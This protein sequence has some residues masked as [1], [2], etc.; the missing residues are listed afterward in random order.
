M[1]CAVPYALGAK[2][3]YP[4]RPVIAFVGDGAMQMIG[5]NALID[6]A[7]YAERWDEQDVRDRACST[8]A[9]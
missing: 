9:T 6:I 5:I 8:T 4:D 2:F 1:G 7:W 3:A